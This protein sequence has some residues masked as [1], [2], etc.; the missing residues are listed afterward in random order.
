MSA[1]ASA[2]AILK[3]ALMLCLQHIIILTQSYLDGC[4]NI[5]KKYTYA[6]NWKCFPASF[7]HLFWR[8]K[9]DSQ[10]SLKSH[11]NLS[12]LSISK[13]KTMHTYFQWNFKVK[14]FLIFKSTNSLNIIKQLG[15]TNM[16]S[17]RKLALIFSLKN[18]S[19]FSDLEAWNCSKNQQNFRCGTKSNF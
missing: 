2:F 5:C 15:E 1:S 16:N 6:W 10:I 17:K 9:L 7:S 14:K 4:E 12:L 19:L 13:R 11:V 8:S 3:S 18:E